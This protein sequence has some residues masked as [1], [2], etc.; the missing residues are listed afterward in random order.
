VGKAGD[1]VGDGEAEEDFA[2]NVDEG[3]EDE[4]E[5]DFAGFYVG[6]GGEENKHKDDA[7]SAQDPCVEEE[8]V[9]DGSD[10]GSSSDHD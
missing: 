4:G 3:D 10:N 1:V 2:A 7:A 9:K 6:E 8:D 5:R